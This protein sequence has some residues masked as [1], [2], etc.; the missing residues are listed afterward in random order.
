[1]KGGGFY[2]LWPLMNHVPAAGHVPP[3]SFKAGKKTRLFDA[4]FI[5]TRSFY[6]DRLGTDIR[7]TQKK[8]GVFLQLTSTNHHRCPDFRKPPAATPPLLTRYSIATHA[9]TENGHVN[10]FQDTTWCFCPDKRLSQ[11]AT[12]EI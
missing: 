4:M 1:M 7:K 10:V 5:S 3:P 12:G 6:H 9:Q 8:S 2:K 11:T